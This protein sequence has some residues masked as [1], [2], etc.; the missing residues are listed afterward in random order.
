M[1]E[2]CCVNDQKECS[3]RHC[4]H[5]LGIK[6]ITQCVEVFS[7]SPLHFL[8]GPRQALSSLM[9]LS[10]ACPLQ[11]RCHQKEQSGAQWHWG[12]GVGEGVHENRPVNYSHEHEQLDNSLADIYLQVMYEK[13]QLPK[14]LD[15]QKALLPDRELLVE[16]VSSSF[17]S[18]PPRHTP[19]Q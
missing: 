16:F 12:P 19:L 4:L 14:Y 10:F 9:I 17:P 18:H 1:H 11:H 8:E 5:V 6:G 2:P 13:Y 7:D 3:S 15:I